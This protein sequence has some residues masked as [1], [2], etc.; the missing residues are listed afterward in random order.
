MYVRVVFGLM[1]V[2]V[3]QVLLE[4]IFFIKQTGNFFPPKLLIFTLCL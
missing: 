3:R 4:I 1:I 2:Y